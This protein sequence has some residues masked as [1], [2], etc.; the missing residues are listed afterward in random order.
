MCDVTHTC[1][2]EP[3]AEYWLDEARYYFK[4]RESAQ[5][6]NL[7]DLWDKRVWE[8]LFLFVEAGDDQQQCV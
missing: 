7:R 4:L 3:D 6:A 2:L 8:N 1:L 5:L